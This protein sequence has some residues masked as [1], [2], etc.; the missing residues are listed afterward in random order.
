MAYA[1]EK[2]QRQAERILEAAYRCLARHGYSGTSMQR[3]ADEAGT[4][5]RMVHYY[6]QSRERLL[7]Q[8]AR[9]VG[10]R[11]LAQVQEA[12]TGLEEPAEIVTTGIGRLWS[13]VTADPQ[14]QAVYFGLAAES[15]TDPALRETLSY[16]NDGYRKLI[17]SLIGEARGRGIDLRWDEGPLTVLIIAGIQ[18]FT[19]QFLERG[20]TDELQGAIE[21]FQRWLTSVVA[22]PSG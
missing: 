8:V 19:L 4:Q 18:G 17:H 1:T 5:K 21:D 22:A 7:D 16:I 20:E 10:D 9:R 3:V 2:G 11:L 12:I 14:L 6:F 15:A 13:E